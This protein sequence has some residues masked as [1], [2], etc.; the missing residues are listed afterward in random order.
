MSRKIN[1]FVL[2]LL[3]FGFAGCS[4]PLTEL[5]RRGDVRGVQRALERGR[6]VNARTP[7]GHSPLTLASREGHLDVVKAL[8]QAGSDL[9]AV[10]WSLSTHPRPRAYRHQGAALTRQRFVNADSSGPQSRFMAERTEIDV[11]WVLKD[12]RT[13]L[14]LAAEKGHRDVVA[15]LVDSGADVALTNGG[16]WVLDTKPERESFDMPAYPGVP[17]P[18]DPGQLSDRVLHQRGYSGYGSYETGAYVETD[19]ASGKLAADGYHGYPRRFH[20]SR[21]R[22]TAVDFAYENGHTDIVEFLVKAGGW[23]ANVKER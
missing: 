14:M 13:P 10:A 20:E 3:L 8:I 5:S 17:P 1:Q 11:V 15:L 19:D 22:K 18:R 2:V 16:Y 4:A 12:G 9:N 6:D 23:M 7:Q 21:N